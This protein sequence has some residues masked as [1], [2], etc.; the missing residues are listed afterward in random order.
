M[1]IEFHFIYDIPFFFYFNSNTEPDLTDFLPT[2][3]KTVFFL[4]FF[5]TKFPFLPS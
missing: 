5:S 3:Q 4:I 1:A 2:L